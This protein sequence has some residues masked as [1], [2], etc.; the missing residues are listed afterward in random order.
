MVSPVPKWLRTSEEENSVHSKWRE[1]R[2]DLVVSPAQ[3]LTASRHPAKYASGLSTA[4]LSLAGTLDVG[5]PFA[6]TGRLAE[7]VRQPFA[8]NEI[9]PQWFPA[10]EHL[11]TSLGCEISFEDA[12]AIP[13]KRDTLIF[14]PPYYPRTDRRKL[15]A[16]DDAKRGRVVGYRTGYGGNGVRGF[17]G[18]PGGVEGIVGYRTAMREVFSALKN[19]GRRMFVVVKNQTR[20]GVELRLDLDTI[21]TAQEAGWSCTGRHG[22]EPPP[23]MWNRYNLQRG[24]GVAV[25]DVL[26]FERG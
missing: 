2:S 4:L 25:E 6:G 7:E 24:T 14:S 3:G 5:D 13:W 21:L 15:A 12:R 26:I 18:D 17:I 1:H 20:L 19:N 9:D 22:W 11:R 23:S 8:L 16:H 10:L